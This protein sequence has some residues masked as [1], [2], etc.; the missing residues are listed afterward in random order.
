MRTLLLLAVVAVIAQPAAPRSQRLTFRA[1][2][3]TKLL[4]GRS[5]PED[6]DPSRPRP[7]VLALHPG[8]ARIPFYGDQFMRQIVLPGLASL[9]P[10][11]VAPDCPS[12]A[13]SDPAADQ[14]VTALIDS[15][16]A[17]RA[18][19][20]GIDTDGAIYVSGASRMT[21]M[22]ITKGR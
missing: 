3:G 4:Y 20:M 22:K 7:L 5:I 19:G 15:V 8:G 1:P 12:P 9:D 13:W 21:V 18:H 17:D 10:I 16:M 14:A 2:D 6:Y 11:V